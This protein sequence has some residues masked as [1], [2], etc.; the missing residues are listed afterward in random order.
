MLHVVILVW[1]LGSQAALVFMA[2]EMW[3]LALAVVATNLL[4]GVMQERIK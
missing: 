3:W 1:L 2:R 4:I